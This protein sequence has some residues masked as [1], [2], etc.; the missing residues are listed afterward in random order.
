MPLV[1]PASFWCMVQQHTGVLWLSMLL[2]QQGRQVCNH[3]SLND[4]GSD[5]GLITGQQQPELCGCSQ[6]AAQQPICG[7]Q[8]QR[9]SSLH[10]APSIFNAAR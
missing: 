6:L 2:V 7:S 1:A 9:A 10:I 5:R 4:F 3:C 8:L